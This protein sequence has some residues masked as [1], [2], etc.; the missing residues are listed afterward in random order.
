MW[1]RPVPDPLLRSLARSPAHPLTRSP[2]AAGSSHT[3]TRF[4]RGG[5]TFGFA[6]P[7]SM[8]SSSEI[9][10]KHESVSPSDDDAGGGSDAD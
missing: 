3:D 1:P 8:C 5:L 10:V 6:D 4:D 2:V 7:S 9:P